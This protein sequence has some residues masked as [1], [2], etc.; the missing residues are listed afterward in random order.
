MIATASSLGDLATERYRELFV[1]LGVAR[2]T[3]LRPEERER[4]RRPEAA[5]TLDD[6]TGVFL[7]GGNQLRLTSIVAGTRLGDA[8]HLAHDR[9]AVIA[10]TS[11]RA[12]ARWRRT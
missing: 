6:A 10:G 8:L 1:E 11:A 5:A 7:T 4:G 3:G 9:G 12:R 2:V